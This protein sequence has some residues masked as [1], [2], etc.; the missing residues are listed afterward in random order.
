VGQAVRRGLLLGFTPFGPL[1]RGSEVDNVAHEVA[2]R[3]PDNVT[4]AILAR[5]GC[6]LYTPVPWHWITTT[7]SLRSLNAGASVVA[8][9]Y[10]FCPVAKSHFGPSFSAAMARLILNEYSQWPHISAVMLKVDVKVK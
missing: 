10:F 8:K 1:S 2:R 7:E 4:G 3:Y 5:F 9:A 6:K